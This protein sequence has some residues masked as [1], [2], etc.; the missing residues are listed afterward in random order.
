MSI[1]PRTENGSEPSPD[2]AEPRGTL[3]LAPDTP[4]A[5]GHIISLDDSGPLVDVP[6]SPTHLASQ[7]H[8]PTFDIAASTSS[9]RRKRVLESHPLKLRWALFQLPEVRSY[10]APS[11]QH[12]QSQ[13]Q[14][15]QHQHSAI[16]TPE[17]LIELIVALPGLPRR[18]GD[19][20]FVASLSST[21][22]GFVPELASR[23]AEKTHEGSSNAP[24]MLG[25]LVAAICT[26]YGAKEALARGLID[27]HQC[28][29]ALASCVHSKDAFALAALLNAHHVASGTDV[30]T[31]V[32]RH[33]HNF[34][35]AA[36]HWTL[37]HGAAAASI[38]LAEIDEALS[39]KARRNSSGPAGPPP[40][41]PPPPAPHSSHASSTGGLDSR[42]GSMPNFLAKIRSALSDEEPG[43]SMG[44]LQKS[45]TAG[46]SALDMDASTVDPTATSRTRQASPR[47]APAAAAAG[48][49]PHGGAQRRDPNASQATHP[50]P[51]RRPRTRLGLEFPT[52]VPNTPTPAATVVVASAV[53]AFRVERLSFPLLTTASWLALALKLHLHGLEQHLDALGLGRNAVQTVLA[54]GGRGTG[55]SG[56]RSGGGSSGGGGS[57]SSSGP[58][59]TMA[60]PMQGFGFALESKPGAGGGGSSASAPAGGGS[61]AVPYTVGPTAKPSRDVVEVLMASAAMAAVALT[62]LVRR[63]GETKLAT[64]D[65]LRPVPHPAQ[66]QRSNAE[67]VNMHDGMA[68]LALRACGLSIEA[69]GRTRSR[70][71]WSVPELS[72][73]PLAFLHLAASC[74]DFLVTR[75]ISVSGD[76]QRQLA[77]TLS[78][79]HRSSGISDVNAAPPFSS[80]LPAMSASPGGPIG[81]MMGNTAVSGL[82]STAYPT[83][84]ASPQ[85]ALNGPQF[86]GCKTPMPG[87]GGGGHVGRRP[88]DGSTWPPLRRAFLFCLRIVDVL[89]HATGPTP[90]ALATELHAMTKQLEQCLAS[91][92]PVL[93]CAVET[94]LALATLP[95]DV[96]SGALN[97][98]T[99]IQGKRTVLPGQSATATTLPPTLGSLPCADY[100]RGSRASLPLF[101]VDQ[102][103]WALRVV[104]GVFPRVCAAATSGC[105]AG[106]QVLPMCGTPYVP[107]ANAGLNPNA[108]FTA[109]ASSAQL[110]RATSSGNL[111]NTSSSS[112]AASPGSNTQEQR[113]RR[114]SLVPPATLYRL[115]SFNTFEQRTGDIREVPA[116]LELASKTARAGYP[117]V[118]SAL[119]IGA[120]PVVEADGTTLMLP[121]AVANGH[122]TSP[123]FLIAVSTADEARLAPLP[124]SR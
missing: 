101:N 64:P 30:A 10:S 8:S 46:G 96:V 55:A 13:P 17:E 95:D 92:D 36:E 80:G 57:S 114:G 42:E 68:Y 15:Q 78:V 54:P 72:E 16:N 14:P 73:A 28:L 66:A 43:P 121:V 83:P 124:V 67:M 65:A 19:P 74:I 93:A 75:D 18:L 90:L 123:A 53:I 119:T 61:G 89:A 107:P 111:H 69:S 39:E 44:T 25:T 6:Q 33:T 50:A 56:A 91:G 59:P 77:A 104:A 9:I 3:N 87:S 29:G 5:D 98:Y 40:P 99:T 52:K 106:V 88:D 112:R 31:C 71:T 97:R 63:R 47:P 24:G 34:A 51:A 7:P 32:L 118:T 108:T 117:S 45:T 12:P 76:T 27:R 82:P 122:T 41:P 94:A 113:W 102:G 109:S 23:L 84:L 103:C 120:V 79:L 26:A 60:T 35:G 2:P 11:P 86:D 4:P 100:H 110:R 20:L 49:H 1:T 70:F 85:I 38:V 37:A 62:S 58:V 21:L 22:P 105:A 116:L 81:I 48:K 115:G